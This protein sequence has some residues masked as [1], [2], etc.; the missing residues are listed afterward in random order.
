[1]WASHPS[2][3]DRERNIKQR[4]LE[5]A[6]DDRPAWQ[7]FGKKKALRREL[8][9]LLYAQGG[10]TA[11][12]V[13]PAPEV[14]R[15]ILEERQEMEQAEHYHGLYDDRIIAPGPLG[16]QLRE[17]EA[18][19]DL[20]LAALR[21]AAGR[22]TGE[23]LKEL[24]ERRLALYRRVNILSELVSGNIEG[25]TARKLLDGDK[26]VRASSAQKL[27]DEAAA[28]RDATDHTIDT[29][30]RAVFR[31]FVAKSLGTP[32]GRDLVRRYRFLI[33]IQKQIKRLNS[34]DIK[35]GPI[36]SALGSGRELG[37]A[38]FRYIVDTFDEA[39]DGLLDVLEA[40]RTTKMVPMAHLADVSSV[41]DFV[42]PEMLLEPRVEPLTGE[43]VNTLVR[44]LGQVLGRLRKLHFKNLGALL[45]QQEQLDPE[46]FVTTEAED[47]A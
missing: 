16:K 5:L 25:P 18:A 1:M 4:Y 40:C 21:Q 33:R 39:R 37:E 19:D 9:E 42:L 22:Y 30:D 45:R 7:L 34:V 15:Q 8:T 23:A 24:V 43:W 46:L 17:L 26:R 35:L 20:D 12:A 11:K 27:L 47:E 10:R 31:Y 3:Y 44:Q 6:P 2:N 14:H 29:I 28:E 32:E 13:L 36:L 38:D 41:R